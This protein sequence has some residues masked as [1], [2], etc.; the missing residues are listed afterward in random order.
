M[1]VEAVELKSRLHEYLEQ[2]RTTGESITICQGATPLAT[3]A[4]LPAPVPRRN[5]N[6]IDRLLSAPAPADLRPL[7]RDEIYERK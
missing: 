6:L 4:P 1:N 3:L 7:N 5:G 2:I